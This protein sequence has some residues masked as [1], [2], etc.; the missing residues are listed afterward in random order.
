MLFISLTQIFKI[1]HVFAKDKD[2]WREKG[3]VSNASVKIMSKT[4]RIY[5]SLYKHN[6]VFIIIIIITYLLIET[7][8]KMIDFK[9]FAEGVSDIYSV[10]N[11]MIVFSCL[12]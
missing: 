5:I 9:T 3:C 6:C 10:F 1:A 12:M 8:K 2:T 7:K 11:K 4:H